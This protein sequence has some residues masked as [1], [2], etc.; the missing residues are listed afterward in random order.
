MML[1]T[2]DGRHWMFQYYDGDTVLG[3]RNDCF[4]AYDYL[5]SRDTYDEGVKQYAMQGH[6]SWLWYL[7][8]ANFSTQR[9]IDGK[10]DEATAINLTSVCQDMRN[11]GKF[12][13][14]YVLGIMND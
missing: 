7:L 5:T 8:R 2:M 10:A 4:L 6:D 12:S 11:S 1:Y 13:S 14:D 3:E 9:Y